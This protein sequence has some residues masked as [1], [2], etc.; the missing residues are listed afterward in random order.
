M[1]LDKMRKVY[2]QSQVKSCIFCDKQATTKNKQGVLVCPKHKDQLVED[3][4]CQCGYWL[5]LKSGKYGPYFSCLNCGNIN[6]EKA[7]MNRFLNEL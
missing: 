2:G 5:E 3:I 6:F 1:I 4:K 7:M